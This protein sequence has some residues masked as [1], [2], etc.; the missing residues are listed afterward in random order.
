M[1]RACILSLTSSVLLVLVGC[2][3]PLAPPRQSVATPRHVSRFRSLGPREIRAL[4]SSRPEP[5]TTRETR[6]RR[7][8]GERQPQEPQAQAKRYPY[9]C[10]IY[11]G[12]LE[13]RINPQIR[14]QLEPLRLP[15]R[16]VKC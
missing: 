3:G 13:S 2:A 10:W 9:P 11:R 16:R 8:T 5:A 4:E 14:V 15:R 12:S 1:R 6:S 7:V